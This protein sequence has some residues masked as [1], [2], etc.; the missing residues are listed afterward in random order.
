MKKHFTRALFAS[1]FLIAAGSAYAGDAG[2]PTVP[3]GIAGVVTSKAGPEAGVWVVAETLDLATRFM[4]VVVTDD[5]GRYVLPELPKANYK[6]F[7]R[8]Y[9]L[10]DSTPVESTIGKKLNLTATVAPT[11]KAAAEYY[12]PNYWLS[13]MRMPAENEFPGTGPKGNG[14]SPNIKTQQQ[15]IGEFRICITCHSLGSKITRDTPIPTV[16]GWLQRIQK[17]RPEGDP[18]LAGYHNYGSRRMLNQVT[19]MGIGRT[20]TVLADWTK[21]VQDGDLPDQTPPRPTGVERNIVLTEWDWGGIPGEMGR[22]M[23]DI[24][25]TDR[26][27]PVLLPETK[28]YGA[29]V[30]TGT[31]GWF[32][33]KTNEQNEVRIPGYQ[34]AH[35]TDAFPHT[36]MIDQKG[37]VWNGGGKLDPLT[38]T[39]D[40]TPATQPAYCADPSN[41]FAKLFPIPMGTG[42]R[43]Q[44]TWG[45]GPSDR[46]GTIIMYDPAEKKVFQHL[47][48]FQTHHLNFAHNSDD[49]LYFSG[50][51]KVI[52]WV[53]TKQYDAT[54]RDT[55][56]STGWCPMVLDTNGD[57]KI[58]QD[59]TAWN[60]T[61]GQAGGGED[62][63]GKA[64]AASKTDAGKDTR[65]QG[66]MYGIE[67]DP[68]STAVWLAK[69]TPT[70]PSGIVRFDRGA[71]P[72]E[73]CMN[74]LYEPPMQANGKYPALGARGITVDSKGVAWVS[75]STGQMGK[76]DR[77]L[78]KVTKG[79][80]ATGQQCPEGWKFFD[81]P[82]PKLADGSIGTAD[83]HYVVWADLYDTSGLGKDTII[84]PGSNSDSLLAFNQ[85]TEKF[86]VM[87]VPYPA[88][89]YTRNVEGRIDD[90]KAGWKGKGLWSS[91]SHIPVWHQEGGDEGLGPTL[92]KF[93]VRP[94]PLSF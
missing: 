48:C 37:R 15:Y 79:P 65:I 85:Q 16:E 63:G 25:M 31:L 47:I 28:I 35:D 40:G 21:R 23:H 17:T 76:F 73:T 84:L 22:F 90:A 82:G 53:D 57:G 81:A 66:F 61:G 94:D 83:F 71:N 43:E 13:L 64:T 46:T 51:S 52:G 56:K 14:I 55:Q 75:F 88:A 72:P 74:E 12:P 77:N 20:L 92:V 89:F 91:F 70:T 58:T 10:V 7:V 1:T 54:K 38:K 11:K 9:G 36:P 50:D 6:I 32:D 2:V 60:E 33:P 4:K 41:K 18:V 5:Q 62:D 78:C 42:G 67:T 24:T 19:Q 49:T 93:Q 3:N 45:T 87:R 68:S 80:T 29:G 34:E 69:Y 30:F 8:G 39:E 86:S 59:R 27:N 44:K 26:R